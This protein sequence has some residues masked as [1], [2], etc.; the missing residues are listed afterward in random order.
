[1]DVVVAVV[2]WTGAGLLLAAYALASAERI[3]AGGHVFQ[4]LNLLGAVALTLNS[5]CHQAWPSA[6]L[7]TAWITIGMATL[8][9][10]SR[11]RAQR[12]I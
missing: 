8:A 10:G 4:V 12:D 7:N 3:P 5:A 11:D 9:R 6:V 1:M 2:G